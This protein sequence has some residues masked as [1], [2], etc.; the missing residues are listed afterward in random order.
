MAPPRLMSIESRVEESQKTTFCSRRPL[1]INATIIIGLAGALA[2]SLLTVS[3]NYFVKQSLYEQI[4]R[5]SQGMLA[6]LGVAGQ[7]AATTW[8]STHLEKMVNDLMETIPEIASID[9]EA[10]GQDLINT[11]QGS[12]SSSKPAPKS[13]R[14]IIKDGRTIGSIVIT[15]NSEELNQINSESVAQLT[16]AVL[17]L[18]VFAGLLIA[19]L[20]YKLAIAPINAIHTAITKQDQKMTNPSLGSSREVKR[21]AVAVKE[22]NTFQRKLELAAKE[23]KVTASLLSMA[24]PSISLH[25]YLALALN[26]VLE[27]VSWLGGEAKRGAVFLANEAGTL[28]YVSS[29]NIGSQVAN[30]CSRIALGYCFYGKAAQAQSILFADHVDE[31]FDIH[32]DD[33]ADHG[34]YSVPLIKDNKLLG[35]LMLYVP[36]GHQSDDEKISF[37]STVAA[38]LGS[39]VQQKEYEQKLK[40]TSDK[41]LK[42]KAEVESSHQQ[43]LQSEKLSSIGQ[44][45]AGI[46]H[47]INTPV[48]FVGDNTR[49]LEDAFTD[50][51]E[52]MSGY[53]TLIKLNDTGHIPQEHLQKLRDISEEIELDYLRGEIPS[54]I[55]QS[56][57]GIERISTIVQSMKEFSHPGS[58]DMSQCDIN[59][60]IL[61]TINVSRNEWKYCTELTTDLDESLPLIPCL[62]GELNQVILNIIVNA[63]HAIID[64]NTVNDGTLGRIHIS[65]QHDENH[66][67]IRVKDSGGG[68]PES[69]RTKV[70]DPFFTTKEVGKGTGQGLS[71]AHSVITSKHNGTIHV[72]I[73]EGKGSTFIIK[74]PLKQQPHADSEDKV[75]A[76]AISPPQTPES[77]T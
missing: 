33:V 54:A 41:L 14:D 24:T 59:K 75:T 37:L 39:V 6:I 38:A 29:K 2:I 74:L 35:L 36:L 64:K 7:R 16:L 62:A 68:M 47:E 30:N 3:I 11:S 72:E 22:L 10:Y 65:T 48:Q 57:E 76:H 32:L 19:G 13:E 60:G 1:W 18:M 43:V 28:E 52:L 27:Q 42:A 9:I 70:F 77:I 63:T 50:L 21:I 44:L 56:L 71:I 17:V 31:R 51:S 25:D 23:D 4:Q 66:A 34:Q 67:I 40:S 61:S 5:E 53:D 69:I 20:F 12:A 55:S 8:D 15:W 46:A 73:D 26:E 58:I 49:F 45:A